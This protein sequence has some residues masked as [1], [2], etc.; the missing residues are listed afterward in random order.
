[1]LNVSGIFFKGLFMSNGIIILL[2]C[3][4]FAE[5]FG[6]KKHSRCQ[7]VCHEAVIGDLSAFSLDHS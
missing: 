4:L 6:Q 5:S 2:V 1:M 3:V 7:G